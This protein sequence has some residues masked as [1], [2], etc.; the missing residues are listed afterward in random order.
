MMLN[1]VTSQRRH[2]RGTGSEEIQWLLE[3]RPSP[4]PADTALFETEYKRSTQWWIER[5]SAKRTG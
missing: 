3:A 1:L 2:P 5:L 4:S